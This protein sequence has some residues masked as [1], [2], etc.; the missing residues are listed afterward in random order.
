MNKPIVTVIP[1]VVDRIDRNTQFPA[2]KKRAAAYARVST[3]SEEQENSYEAQVD[4]YT[5]HI[6]SN[7]EWEFVK[8]YADEGISAT[9]TKGRDGFKEMVRDALAGKIDL[10]L[11]KSIS[12]FARNTVDTLVAIREL[13]AK[14]VEVYFE[15]QNISTLDAKGE[16]LIT[17]MSSLAQEESRSISEN[18]T[19]GQ[20]KR[21]ADGKVSMPYKRFL[22]YE[23]GPDGKPQIV[24]REAKT[25]R[26]IYE[27]FLNGQT[28]R[29]IAAYLTSQGVPTPAG[30]AVWSV[31]T[32]QSVLKNEKYSG[33]AILQKR[34][35]V[36]YLTKATKINEGEVPQYFVEDSHPAIVSPEVYEIAQG[37]IQRRKALG[38]RL[39]GSGPFACRIVCG[40]C[41]SFYGSKVWD[42]NNKY[43]RVVWQCN[44]KFQNGAA[45][46]TPHITEQQAKSAFISGFNQLLNEKE[47]YIKRYAAQAAELGDNFLF[48]KQTRRLETECAEISEMVQTCITQNARNAQDQARYQ[49][50]YDDLLA[51]Y[52]ASKAELDALKVKKQE[53]AIRKERLRWF[54]GLLKPQ[55]PPLTAFDEGLWRAAAESLV[56]H[57][58][59]DIEVVFKSGDKIHVR[60]DK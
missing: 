49:E 47:R 40:V 36:D 41:G 15:T 54:L 21:M 45:C 28:Y 5:G 37:E 60:L 22:G 50:R 23:K 27:M 8:V 53:Q 3:D 17:I 26:K 10:I 55:E 51:R 13:K 42:S 48:D 59:D 32:I 12:R 19:W 35:T 30:K 38:K 52:D 39:G 9:S 16:L 44:R 57:S 14:G 25:I 24:E 18:V 2:R 7:P 4:F 31:S 43:R 20:R 1:A 6:Q 33:N 58:L 56:V 46:K 29:E 34:F 11:T